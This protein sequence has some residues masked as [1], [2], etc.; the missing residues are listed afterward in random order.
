MVPQLVALLFGAIEPHLDCALVGRSLIEVTRDYVKLDP[1][2]HTNLLQ[3]ALGLVQLLLEGHALQSLA[4]LLLCT[5]LDRGWDF[6]N[7]A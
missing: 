2:A 6:R 7:Q 3:R 1:S 5:L 4:L